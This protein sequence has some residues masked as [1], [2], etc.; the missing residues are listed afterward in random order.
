MSHN[1]FI[2]SFYC[3]LYARGRWEGRGGG[4]NLGIILVRVCEPVFRNLSHSYT[5]PLKKRTHSYTRSSEMLTHSK[6]VHSLN[7][8]PNFSC[9]SACFISV[10]FKLFFFSSYCPAC[11]WR[12]YNVAL[13]SMQY[14]DVASMLMQGCINVMCPLDVLTYILA[15]ELIKEKCSD[16]QAVKT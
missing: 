15:V 11:T 10:V 3:W 16:N 12:L 14:Y 8:K 4:G 7:C 13:T 5:W 6:V 9:P 2:R 1:C